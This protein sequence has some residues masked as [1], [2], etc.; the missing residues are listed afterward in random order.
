MMTV[1]WAVAMILAEAVEISI[2]NVVRNARFVIFPL[3]SRSTFYAYAGSKSEG[4]S[5]RT[6]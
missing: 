3:Q 5:L 4:Q 2:R 6:N 1:A